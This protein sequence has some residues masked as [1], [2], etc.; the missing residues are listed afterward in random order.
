MTC[1]N[2]FK[3]SRFAKT[4]VNVL[5]AIPMESSLAENVGGYISLH[6]LYYIFGDRKMVIEGL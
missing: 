3:C 6:L 5:V 1:A 2:D 4:L